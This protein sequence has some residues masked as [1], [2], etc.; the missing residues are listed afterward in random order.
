MASPHIEKANRNKLFLKEIES[1]HKARYYGWE[2][3]VCF[4]CAVHYI[5]EFLNKKENDWSGS[6]TGREMKLKKLSE[7]KYQKDKEFN[8][9]FSAFN[10]LKGISE[11]HRY[12]CL[13]DSQTKAACAKVNMSI[14]EAFVKSKQL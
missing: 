11:S 13:P 10:A 6:H 3:T 5:E 1:F 9:M 14:V 2:S 7:G 4:Y 12:F 8:E